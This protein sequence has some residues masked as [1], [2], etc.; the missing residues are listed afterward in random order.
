METKQ[1]VWKETLNYGIIIGLVMVAYT[2]LAWM[3]NLTFKSW[4]SI[5]SLLITFIVLIFLL[6]S[7]RNHYCNGFISYGRSVGAG[8]VI[9]IYASLIM[10]IFTYLLYA[11]IDTGLIEKTLALTEAKMADL[12]QPDEVIDK[13]M[14]MQAKIVRPWMISLGQIFNTLLTGLIMSLIASLFI[15]RKGN[16]LLAEAEEEP[17]Q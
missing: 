12:G 17:A 2:L 9:F 4:I 3:F 5:P 10:A 7:Y 14:E 15:M 1:S 11:F 13:A 8:M 16:P 6:R